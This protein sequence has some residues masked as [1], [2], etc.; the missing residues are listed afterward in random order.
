MKNAI[1]TKHGLHG[2][3]TYLVQSSSIQA[4]WTK[5]G[6]GRLKQVTYYHVYVDMNMETGEE[7]REL[8]RY[9]FS[10]KSEALAYFKS[11]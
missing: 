5:A 8:S 4:G 10:K 6:K 7:N 3:S 11:T 1:K 9:N 2:T